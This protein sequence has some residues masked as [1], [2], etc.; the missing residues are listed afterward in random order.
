MAWWGEIADTS[1]DLYAALS[2]AKRTH[3]KSMMSYLIMM[4]IRLIEMRRILKSTGSIYL[5]CDPTACH[6]LKLVMDAV[7]GARN[8]RNEIVWERA[9]SKAKGSQ[10]MPKSWG[11]NTDIILF[12]ARSREASI[13]PYRKLASEEILTKFPKVDERGGRY[14]DDTA[15]IW[16]TPNMGARPNLCY[17]WRGFTNP[18]PSG[19]RLSRGR[20]EEEYQKGNIIIR[21]DGKLERRAYERDYRGEPIGNL[22]TDIAPVTG[23]EEY[24]DYPTQKPLALLERIIRASSEKG[25]WVLDPFCGCATACSAAERLDRKWIGIDISPKAV[26]LLNERLVREAGLDKFTKGAGDIIR[27]TAIPVRGGARSP[28]IKDMLYGSQQGLCNLCKQWFQYRQ[29][30]V[31]HK[32]PTS[33]GGPD[34]DSNLQLLCHHCNMIKGDRTMAEARVRLKELGIIVPPPTTITR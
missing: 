16:S 11:T 25:D 34:V 24:L 22:W 30:D 19:W 2:A 29:M 17:E 3:G 33:K 5:H 27:R 18:H 4:G 8:F 21:S 15:H 31:D 32:T 7:F 14:K 12:Y 20:L 10:H 13:R 26:D 1:P 9:T 28:C 23:G 6:Y